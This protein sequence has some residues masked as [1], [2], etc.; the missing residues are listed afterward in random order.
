MDIQGSYG[1]IFE[2]KITSDDYASALFNF[3]NNVRGELHLDLLQP[4]P[5]RNVKLIGS[6]GVIIGD[7]INKTLMISLISD[8]KWKIQ[9]FKF[10]IDDIYKE[11]SINVLNFFFQEKIKY[12]YFRGI[13]SCNASCRG[14]KKITAFWYKSKNSIL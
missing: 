5:S 7:L 2:L 8:P 1:T 4:A 3:E 10:D 6:K 13:I 14:H 9:K 12:N 11:E